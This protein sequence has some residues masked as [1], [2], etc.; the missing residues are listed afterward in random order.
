M[1]P[2]TW[3]APLDAQ[4]RR[5]RAEGAPWDDIARH[6]GISCE[7]ARARA[8]AIGARPPPPDFEPPPPNPAREPLPAGDPR[9]WGAMVGGTELSDVDYPLPWFPR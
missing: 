5:M 7:A 3:T 6:F 2:L 1:P 8:A 4:L 9:C